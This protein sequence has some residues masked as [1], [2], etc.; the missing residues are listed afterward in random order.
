MKFMKSGFG[1]HPDL[2]F[3]IGDLAYGHMPQS[4]LHID[5]QFK[6]GSIFLESIRT[7]FVPEVPQNNVFI[8]PG[9]H[10]VNRSRIAESELEWLEKRLS[11]A[12]EKAMFDVNSIIQSTGLQWQ[13]FIDHLSNFTMFLER[14]G[15]VHLL[16]DRNRLIYGDVRSV[17][18]YKVGIMGFNSA[19]SSGR[20]G[21]KGKL[22]LGSWQIG[23]LARKIG[24]NSLNIALIHHP[25]NWFNEHEDPDLLREIEL[26]SDFL[27][28]GHEHT[29]W[30]VRKNRHITIA[31]GACYFH[32]TKENGY[33]FVRVV[34]QLGMCEIFL[35]SYDK[36]GGGW[37]PRIIHGITDNNGRW[38]LDGLIWLK[39]QQNF[40]HHDIERGLEFSDKSKEFLKIAVLPF[41]YSTGGTLD[42][43]LVD[44]FCDDIVLRLSKI[45]SLRVISMESTLHLRESRLPATDI[46]VQLGIDVVLTGS[47]REF[48]QQKLFRL[49]VALTDVAS[50]ITILAENYDFTYEKLA[51]AQTNVSQLVAKKL[52]IRLS[53]V[54]S[55]N[56]TK[57]YTSSP[58]AYEFYLRGKGLLFKNSEQDSRLS[59][60]MFNQ[61]LNRDNQFVDAIA[62]KAYALWKRYFHGWD[63]DENTLIEALKLAEKAVSLNPM[64]AMA[65]MSIVRICWDLGW[66]LRALEEGKKALN[67][68]PNSIDALICGGR[69][70][71]NSGM[72][73]KSIPLVEK[74]LEI[75][76][77]NPAAM[78]LLIFNY[79][80][81]G[82]YKLATEKGKEYLTR[83][84]DDSNSCWAIA[85]AWIHLKEFDKAI[86][87]CKFGISADQSNYTLWLVLGYAYKAI[88]N[89]EAAINAWNSGI[90]A[91]IDRLD[92]MKSSENHRT[93]SW[94]AILYAAANRSNEAIEEINRVYK[95]NS[96][97]GYSLYRLS[98]AYVEL[99]MK[100]EAIKM[101]RSS[102]RY[103]FLS[104][105]MMR[106]EELLFFSG[107][108][109]EKAYQTIAR[110]LEKKLRKLRQKY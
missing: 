68:N 55:Y 4:G 81:T 54:E 34:P 94:L 52:S 108:A 79:V 38:I 71:N 75:E 59:L 20:D 66:H 51:E 62:G 100:Q 50:G 69:A 27:L 29:A 91:T 86:E 23:E 19:W 37:V 76:P 15:Y 46:G 1:L 33:N 56:L 47:L 98:N 90:E 78:K 104:A 2:I 82:H 110:N 60:S 10:D 53:E 87:V 73:D 65:R 49:H 97:N 58:E 40:P 7:C 24:K 9:K 32:S 42:V 74:V 31:A 105:Q 35:R 36:A 64:S 16:Q 25:L 103:G 95:F 44:G 11:S 18:N 28:H 92:N 63:A 83:Y 93:R 77:T 102:I 80:M 45:H 21:E 89:P 30:V 8:V 12:K 85:M 57:C 88:G 22:W 106:H 70:Y 61:S 101:L 6:E 3:F 17:E 43:F 96:K 72:A 109:K 14:A 48:Q 67:Q 5:N 26:N 13:R 84:P 99:G 39:S 41:R 107:I